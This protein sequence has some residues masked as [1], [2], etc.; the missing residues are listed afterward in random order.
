MDAVCLLAVVPDLLDALSGFGHW[1]R[2]R[3]VRPT[4]VREVVF[5]TI[6][7]EVPPAMASVADSRVA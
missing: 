6:S 3:G 2:A 5:G 7:A 4:P 1:R